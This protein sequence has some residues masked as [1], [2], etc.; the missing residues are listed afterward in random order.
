MPKQKGAWKQIAGV[1]G[2]PVILILAAFTIAYQFIQPAPP[3]QIVIAAGQP[4]GAYYQYAKAYARFLANEDIELVVKATQGS[5]ENLHLLKSGE[6][7]LALMQG[8]VGDAAKESDLRSLGSLYFEPLWLF[9]RSDLNLTQLD[10]LKGLRIAAGASGSGTRALLERLLRDNQLDASQLALQPLAGEAAADALLQQKIDAAFFVISARSPLIERLIQADE[11]KLASFGRAEAYARRH[12]FLSR[13]TLPEGIIDLRNNR[14][15][16]D[17]SLI[18]PAA[19][20]VA[21]AQLHP[22][23][24]DLMMQAIEQVHSGGGWL[25]KPGQFPSENFVDYPLSKEAKRYF[26]NGPPFLQRYMPF[27]AASLVDRLKVMLLPLLVLLIPLMK[28]MPPIYTWR[29][30]SRIYRWY[31]ELERI[32]LAHAEDTAGE[33]NE[34]LLQELDSLDDEVLRIHVPLS[35]SD[36]LYLLR[37]HINLVRQRI[38]AT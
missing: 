32:D 28:L 22:A 35:F 7:D 24:T 13:L 5:V 20:L 36:Q 3:R 2:P 31:R 38:V 1:F 19:T 23:I 17:V 16:Q 11:V 18:A 14:P 15:E 37:E 21:G 27:W 4:D 12:P 25:E 30:R 9:Y 29:M 33:Q 34:K 10:G 26:K 6:V 8:G